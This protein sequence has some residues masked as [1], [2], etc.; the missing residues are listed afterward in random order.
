MR[1]RPRRLRRKATTA[2]PCPTWPSA[3]VTRWERS[4]RETPSGKWLTMRRLSAIRR[5]GGRSIPWAWEKVRIGVVRKL[6]LTPTSISFSSESLLSGQS[7]SKWGAQSGL[8][9]SI[10]LDNP[11]E[12]CARRKVLCHQ[13][14]QMC[15]YRR[16]RHISLM[17]STPLKS[18]VLNRCHYA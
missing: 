14:A 3:R 4:R 11:R 1:R 12:V 2:F 16:Y 15:W 10:Q 6:C 7:D 13:V 9:W 5:P 17:L 18:Y 8:Q